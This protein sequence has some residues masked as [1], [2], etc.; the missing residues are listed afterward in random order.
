MPSKFNY[1]A[2]FR[3]GQRMAHWMISSGALHPCNR[4]EAR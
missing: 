4:N 1:N 2:L 3:G